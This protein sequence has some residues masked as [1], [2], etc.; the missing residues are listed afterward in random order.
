MKVKNKKIRQYLKICSRKEF[1]T[2]VYESKLT[3]SEEK[4]IQ[5]FIL[6]D[7]PLMEIGDILNC[8]SRTAS[9]IIS[10][11]YDKIVRTK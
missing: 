8:S 3:P 7:K 5:L 1:E 11:A 6:E 4:A 2:L 9:K 10:H